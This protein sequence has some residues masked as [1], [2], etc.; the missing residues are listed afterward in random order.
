MRRDRVEATA[1]KLRSAGLHKR[2][3][4]FLQAE[5]A[6]RHERLAKRMYEMGYRGGGTQ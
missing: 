2:H 1:A 6:E 4:E 3:K 5:S